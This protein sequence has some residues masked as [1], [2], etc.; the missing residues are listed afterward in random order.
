MEFHRLPGESLN[1]HPD[2]AKDD[3]QAAR[4]TDVGR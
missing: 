2:E 3:M 1:G 4:I